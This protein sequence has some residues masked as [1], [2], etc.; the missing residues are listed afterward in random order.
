MTFAPGST[1]TAPSC[2]PIFEF[3]RL[4]VLQ[5]IAK[6]KKKP[7]E[8]G[9]VIQFRSSSAMRTATSTTTRTRPGGL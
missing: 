2:R 3:G 8:A 5:E 7:A 1:A 9:P 6:A 4:S